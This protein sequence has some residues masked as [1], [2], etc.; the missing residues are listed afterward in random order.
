MKRLLAV[1]LLVLM[2]SS[3]KAQTFD[4]FWHPRQN[5]LKLLAAPPV[6][7]PIV[8]G[9]SIL[10]FKPTAEVQVSEIAFGSNGAP[11]RATFLDAFGPALTMQHSSQ[12]ANGVNYADWAVSLAILASG[13]TTQAPIFVPEVSLTVGILN[14]LVQVGP[15]YT[16]TQP[17][18]NYSR[19]RIHFAL[20][21]NITNN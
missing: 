3:L 19:F 11:T 6:G 15:A 1:L 17:D 20:G 16:L 10:E 7:V 14:N 13:N 2:V 12:D 4:N 18:L 5:Q 9:G 21:I 8:I